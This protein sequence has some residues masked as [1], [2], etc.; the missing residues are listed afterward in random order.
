MTFGS[1]HGNIRVHRGF[2]FFLC[3]ALKNCLLTQVE[4]WRRR[5][6]NGDICSIYG[7]APGDGLHAIKNCRLAKDVWIKVIPVE[8]QASFFLGN[9]QERLS[10][11]LQNCQGLAFRGVEWSIFFGLVY[12]RIWKNKNLYKFQ[13][14]PWSAEEI[15]KE[16]L[17]WAKQYGISSEV[18][19]EGGFVVGGNHNQIDKRVTFRTCC[20]RRSFKGWKGEWIMGFNRR[21]GRGIIFES[22]L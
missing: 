22:E 21:L 14:F 17:S 3:L 13:G 20:C 12:W 5:I 18:F 2:V 16:S 10:N 4:R 11:N 9:L 6:G 7:L 1:Y 19:P 8:K 15:M